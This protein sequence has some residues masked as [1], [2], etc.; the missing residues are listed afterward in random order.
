VELDVVGH[1]LFA[2]RPGGSAAARSAV[3]C[4]RGL[5]DVHVSQRFAIHDPSTAFE[6][7]KATMLTTITQAPATE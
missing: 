6:L 1:P 4:K 5:D 3:R 2:Q 7:M